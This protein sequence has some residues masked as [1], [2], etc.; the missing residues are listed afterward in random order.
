MEDES[1]PVAVAVRL[2]SGSKAS[3]NVIL[4]P[5]G[6]ELSIVG[7]TIAPEKFKFDH[8][9]PD[10]STQPEVFSRT[11]QPFVQLFFDGYDLFVIMYGGSGS[12]KTY[13][14]Y[15]PELGLE[16]SDK[17]LGLLPRFV[18]DIFADFKESQM[19]LK[20]ASFDVTN[21]DVCDLL[22]PSGGTHGGRRKS[23]LG[24]AD[25]L[26]EPAMEV[27]CTNASEVLS[28]YRSSLEVQKLRNE[29]GCENR[30]HTFF[31]VI[32]EQ[33]LGN[34]GKKSTVTFV[35]LASDHGDGV[36]QQL[37]DVG[38]LALNNFVNATSHPERHAHCMPFQDSLLFRLLRN[39]FE[40]RAL[41]LLVTCISPQDSLEETLNSLKFAKS[42]LTIRNTP[43][44]NVS[45]INN[46]F[47][48][49][50]EELS[51]INSAGSQRPP[52]MI[53]PDLVHPTQFNYLMMPLMQQQMLN[54]YLMM[55]QQKSPSSA[56]PFIPISS[57]PSSSSAASVAQPASNL[58]LKSPLNNVQMYHH[59]QQHHLNANENRPLNLA[60]HAEDHS[61]SKTSQPP[62][63]ESFL[64]S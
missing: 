39:A 18:D 54:N 46:E 21:D 34:V 26:V 20:V 10:Y 49:E 51:Y 44:P 41:T 32:L 38:L 47:M 59:H 37:F 15:G 11:L 57:P 61:P 62:T 5:N 3:K 28:Y 56:S 19:S 43:L 31:K 22:A 50:E 13:T 52:A 29:F 42:A 64:L 36:N 1:V 2:K 60:V 16:I 8:V 35:D 12:G 40:G 45:Q 63:V 58:D 27:P 48:S 14:L 7:G 53:M 4:N 30:S 17:D 23:L 55:L 25:I 6:C 24:K 33:R 9:L